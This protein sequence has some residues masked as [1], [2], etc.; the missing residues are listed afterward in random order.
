MWEKYL[1][2]SRVELSRKAA[3]AADMAGWSTRVRRRVAAVCECALVLELADLALLTERLHVV[4]QKS[5]RERVEE[6]QLVGA[7]DNVGHDELVDEVRAVG[8]D[9]VLD[10]QNGDVAAFTVIYRLC[11][12][13]S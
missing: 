2:V 6:T 10:V 1:L 7:L 9:E 3:R 11:Y 8:E 13:D 5:N 4:V 12:S